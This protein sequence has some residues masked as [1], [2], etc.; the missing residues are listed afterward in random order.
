MDIINIHETSIILG[1]PEFLIRDFVSYEFNGKKLICIHEN[2]SEYQFDLAMV[3]EFR[4]H[5][6]TACPGTD[7]RDPPSFVKRYL[8]YEAQGQCVNVSQGTHISDVTTAT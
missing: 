7:R 1:L 5:L 3:E 2:S 4:K 6:D 8:I